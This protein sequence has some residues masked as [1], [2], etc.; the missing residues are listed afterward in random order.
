M[1]RCG[2]KR[3]TIWIDEDKIETWKCSR[4]GKHKFNDADDDG[5]MTLCTQ[6]Y[7][8]ATNFRDKTTEQA[9]HGGGEGWVRL[10]N[11]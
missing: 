1:K 9:Q 5:E 3:S 10:E 7:K 11:R 4:K 2:F 8:I 6:H